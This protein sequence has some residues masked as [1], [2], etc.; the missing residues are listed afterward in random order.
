YITGDLPQPT[1]VEPRA[2]SNWRANSCL[3]YAIIASRALR[4]HH[5]KEGLVRQVALLQQALSIQCTTNTPLPKTAEKICMLIERAFAMGSITP[6]LLCC[7]ALLNS[8][9]ANFPHA[10]SIISC[11]IAVSMVSAPYT[12]KDICLFLENEQSLQENDHHIYNTHSLTLAVSSKPPRST[13]AVICS[14][15]KH[16]GHIIPYCVSKRGGGMEGKT[17]EESKTAKKLAYEWKKSG[18]GTAKSSP[19]IP[20]TLKDSAGHTYMVMLDSSIQ[21]TAQVAP[22]EFVG[23][24]SDPLP[25]AMVEEV[26]YEGWL[27]TEEFSTSVD[28][29]QNSVPTNEEALTV[30]P[31][32]QTQ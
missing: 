17:I 5:Q 14:N 11:D 22:T 31:L 1:S 27:V 32:N 18:N 3:A 8:L 10:H 13:S 12:S 26:E 29:V 6:D 23:L 15:C 2:H 16:P 24:A 19:K 28:W 9:S 21:S 25:H 4:A 7:I 20:I 30:T